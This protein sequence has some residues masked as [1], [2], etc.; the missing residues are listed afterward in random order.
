MKLTIAL[1]LLLQSLCEVAMGSGPSSRGGDSVAVTFAIRA[2]GL[3]DIAEW[4]DEPTGTTA[5]LV[6]MVDS[7]TPF[8]KL[9]GRPIYKV[10]LTDVPVAFKAIDS[11]TRVVSHRRDFVLFVDAEAG[12]ILK[13]ESTLPSYDEK[14]ASGAIRRPSRLE[15]EKQLDP[16]GT[17]LVTA[18]AGV[19]QPSFLTALGATP[20]ARGAEKV[21]AYYVMYEH[22]SFSRRPVW[23]VET[24]G[25][26]DP[27]GDTY[28][29]TAVDATGMLY[30]T[31][32]P[33]PKE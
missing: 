23:I 8:L 31:N 11:T 15:L 4:Q 22:L 7:T 24:C 16:A 2:M 14:L 25:V 30:R 13:V 28:A 33:V 20:G 6:T 1:V 19:P 12:T 32:T 10:V 21:V 29:R 18:V 9:D 26:P 5:A 27:N 17:G 3:E